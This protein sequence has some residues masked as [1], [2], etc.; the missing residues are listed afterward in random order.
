[1]AVTA[2][3]PGF[4]EELLLMIGSD[5]ASGTLTGIKVLEQKETPGLGDKIETDSASKSVSG[6]R[7]PCGGQDLAWR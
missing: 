5:P 6:E 7:V 2:K 4:Q 3:E 1:V